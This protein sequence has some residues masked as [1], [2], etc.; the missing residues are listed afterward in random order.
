MGFSLLLFGVVG[1]L[2][3]VEEQ[4]DQRRGRGISMILR[5]QQGC[6]TLANLRRGILWGSAFAALYI[7]FVVVLYVLRGGAP[8]SEQ[9]T[10]FGAVILSYLVCGLGGGAIVGLL[11]P[12]TRSRA[13]LTLVGAITGTFVFLCIG[14]IDAGMRWPTHTW[15]P[16][17]FG[18]VLLG[19][20]VAHGLRNTFS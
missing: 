8:F 3:A 9:H 16:C 20:I 6:F 1:Y 17:V 18:G 15:V 12:L 13:G 14:F 4:Q 19:G 7:L 2:W 10:T 5:L 11:I